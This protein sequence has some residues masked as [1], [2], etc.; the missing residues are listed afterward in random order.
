MGY[1]LLIV[2]FA[3]ICLMLLYVD[4]D[5][6]CTFVLLLILGFVAILFILWFTIFVAVSADCVF[7]WVW[8]L[9]V[10]LDCYVVA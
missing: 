1:C 9:V 2:A 3:V 4:L 8:G 6:L 5:L 7:V 10:L